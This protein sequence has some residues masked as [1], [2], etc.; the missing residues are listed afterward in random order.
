MGAESEEHRMAAEPLEGK[1]LMAINLLKGGEQALLPAPPLILRQQ[2]DGN[3]SGI[4]LVASVPQGDPIIVQRQGVL[5]LPRIHQP[6][7]VRLLP[8]L[9]RDVFPPQSVMTVVIGPAGD[10]PDADYAQLSLDVS[11]LPEEDLVLLE[12]YGTT[13]KVTSLSVPH[14]PTLPPQAEL[15]RDVARELLGVSFVAQ[16]AVDLIVGIDCSPSMR[17]FVEDG[18]VEAALNAFAGIASVVDT[19][20]ELEGVLCGRV[21]TRLP[22]QRLDKFATLTV[23]ELRHQ[24]LK[25]G[26]KSAALQTAGDKTL[27]F[28]ITDS[29]PADLHHRQ[30]QPPRLAVLAPTG[31]GGAK[32]LSGD[33][34]GTVLQAS[35]ERP[36]RDLVWDRYQIRPIVESLLSEYRRP[37][38]AR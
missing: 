35:E 30:D 25:T 38:R 20:G 21:A 24:P 17:S 12:P 36:D 4:R 9:G 18:T 7:T 23:D 31:A 14:A 19:N 8:E 10:N 6:T 2:Q 16:H 33:Q 13:I 28:L 1:I 34:L 29:V 26:C 15:A 22:P 11:G 37:R 5:V 32:A 27:T 3:A